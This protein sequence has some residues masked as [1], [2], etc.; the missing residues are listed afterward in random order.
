MGNV[1]KVVW[2]NTLLCA[3]YMEWDIEVGNT[4]SILFLW[5]MLIYSYGLGKHIYGL[6]FKKA[7]YELVNNCMMA[8]YF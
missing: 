2:S 3:F 4:M 6:G 8:I 1:K 7:F 5:Y